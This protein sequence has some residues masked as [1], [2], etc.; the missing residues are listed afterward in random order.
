MFQFFTEAKSLSV[1][2][3]MPES[4]YFILLDISKA[5][6]IIP[7]IYRKGHDYERLELG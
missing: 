5:K 6:D 7:E 3:L 4:G 2:P 1:T